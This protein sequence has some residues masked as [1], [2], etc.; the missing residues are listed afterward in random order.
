MAGRMPRLL[1]VQDREESFGFQERQLKAAAKAA[2]VELDVDRFDLND[3]PAALLGRLESGAVAYDWLVTDLLIDGVE[4]D[5]L[6]SSGMRLIQELS[7]RNLF[8][9]YRPPIAGFR[10]VRCI[11]VCSVCVDHGS[12]PQE[13]LR[14]EFERVRVDLAWLARGGDIKKLAER[15]CERLA[16][17]YGALGRTAH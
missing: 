16:R 3:S 9:A 11:A 6:K 7:S 12:V 2:A 17:E 14:R 13:A 5:P 1:I 8:G 10:G 4:H 15:L